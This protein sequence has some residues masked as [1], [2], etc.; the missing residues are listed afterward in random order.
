MSIFN[1]DEVVPSIFDADY[2]RPPIFQTD[3]PQLGATVQHFNVTIPINQTQGTA[4]IAAVDTNRAS[5]G[6][7][8]YFS[9]VTTLQGNTSSGRVELTD[10]TT[11]TAYRDTLDASRT[12]NV[13]GCVIEWASD[14]VNSVQRGQINI[15]LGGSS[16]T[17]TI[18]AAIGVGVE[19]YL[20][21]TTGSTAM[22]PSIMEVGLDLTNPTTITANRGSGSLDTLNVGFEFIDFKSSVIQSVQRFAQNYTN[23]NTS[24]NITIS[25]VD[26]NNSML[27][28]TG[29]YGASTTWADTLHA[30]TLTGATT[31][32][33]ERN[34]ANA[35]SRTANFVVLEFVPGVI[36]AKQTNA[37]TW[38]T[39]G[40]SDLVISSVDS[41]KTAV[42]SCG[43]L[44]NGITVQNI[45]SAARLLSATSIRY[46]KAGTTSTNKLNAEAV[47][48]V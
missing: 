16:A 30:L 9:S 33:A 40:N 43:F 1:E 46:A 47:T 34:G 18:N 24:D 20:G 44:S 29:Q 14:M 45:F 27:L 37:R 41:A 8:G 15:G 13:V 4:T 48:F 21:R 17:A 26:V 39:P 23:V 5:I 3:A 42:Y 31:V 11:V 22:D 2:S 19:N 36:T 25:S 32:N 28:N 12:V 38:T 6:Y 35:A 10:S 7:G